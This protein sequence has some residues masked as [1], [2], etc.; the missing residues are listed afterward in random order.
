MSLSSFIRDN[1]EEIIREFSAFAKTLMHSDADMSEKDLRD[2]AAEMLT[3]IA[4]DM[5]IRQTTGEQARKSQGLGTA[6]TMA[7][8]AALHA[9]DRIQHGYSSRGVLAE[10]R[11]LRASV[12][13]LYE[14]SGQTDL[15]EVRRFNEAVDEALTDRRELIISSCANAVPA[16]RTVPT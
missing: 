2:H 5:G 1:Q 4:K 12:L 7:E 11:A 15:S 8:S 6:Q 14:N 16:S 13:K 3:A 10:F 9:D